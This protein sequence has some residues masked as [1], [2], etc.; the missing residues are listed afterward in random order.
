METAE[1]ILNNAKKECWSIDNSGDGVNKITNYKTSL[2]QKDSAGSLTNNGPE[3]LE[4]S[5]GFKNGL[6]TELYGITGKN[7]LGSGAF[8]TLEDLGKAEGKHTEV[9]ETLPDKEEDWSIG[10]S[11]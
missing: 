8:I 3:E 1:Y 9:L 6:G 11:G 7:S 4:D 5:L 2:T 10:N